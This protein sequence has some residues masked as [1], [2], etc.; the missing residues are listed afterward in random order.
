MTSDVAPGPGAQ[1]PAKK[2]NLFKFLLIGGAGCLLVVLLLGGGCIG[3]I[4]Y[5]FAAA[6]QHPVYVQSLK[7]VQDNPEAQKL[8][9]TPI[10]GGTPT[11]FSFHA[12]ASSGQTGSATYSV[13]GPNGSGQV[14]VAGKTVNGAWQYTNMT[15]S[16]NGQTIDLLAK[17][18]PPAEA[19]PQ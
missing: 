2:S 18:A 14:Q 7:A 17:P 1:P 5:G 3:A 11:Q 19:A 9:G 10:E 8:L 12:D 6:K 4:F 16:A 13:T 15:L